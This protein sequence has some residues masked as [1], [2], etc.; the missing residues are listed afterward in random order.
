MK[1]KILKNLFNYGVKLK[2]N[3]NYIYY[4]ENG[5]DDDTRENLKNI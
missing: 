1:I 5:S 3:E 2:R 4:V